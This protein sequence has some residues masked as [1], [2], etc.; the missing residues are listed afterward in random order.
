[1]ELGFLI[2]TMPY[3]YENLDTAHHL[4]TA[5]L[6]AGHRVRI[7]LY[8]D[9]VVA[10]SGHIKSGSERNVAS[11]LQALAQR[12][13]E[14]TACATCCRFRGLGREDLVAG[15]KLGGM[16]ALARMADDCDRLVTLGS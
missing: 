6:D 7:F 10:A 5:A 4:A 8:E 16:T 3:T 11:R 2:R 9:S 13:A 14:I 15:A 1:V 12:G